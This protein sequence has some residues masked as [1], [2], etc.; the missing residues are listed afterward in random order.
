MELTERDR[1]IIDICKNILRNQ[2]HEFVYEND[3]PVRA[4]PQSIIESLDALMRLAS[5]ATVVNAPPSAELGDD[6][7][8]RDGAYHGRTTTRDWCELKVCSESKPKA[9]W[10]DDELGC[11]HDR[12]GNDAHRV[13]QGG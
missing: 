13:A 4:V 11:R 6:C 5:Q 2:M 3:Y 9:F 1:Y 12:R 7:N 8:V 10:C